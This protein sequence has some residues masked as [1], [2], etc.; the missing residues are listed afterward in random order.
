MSNK[1][2]FDEMFPS[3]K[4]RED[5]DFYPYYG[6]NLCD[7]QEHCLDKKKVRE[8]FDKLLSTMGCTCNGGDCPCCED[9]RMLNNLKK[10]LGL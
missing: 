3:L 6:V 1:P 8:V 4:G 5:H 2:S 9:I 7:I 10:E